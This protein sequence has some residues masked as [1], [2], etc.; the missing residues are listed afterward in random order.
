MLIHW[1][2]KIVLENLLVDQLL[3]ADMFREILEQ[4]KRS[5]VK[6]LENIHRQNSG[7]YKTGF[8]SDD[9]TAAKI[10]TQNYRY[11]YNSL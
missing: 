5:S 8:Q 10:T 1:K 6:T 2:C 7:Y 4:N 3:T 11:C 9:L